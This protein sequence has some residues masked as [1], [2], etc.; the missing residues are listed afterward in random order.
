LER[1]DWR[2]M[3][4]WGERYI[5]RDE[6]EKIQADSEMQKQGDRPTTT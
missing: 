2:E 5:D 3:I 4:A 1:N 6:D